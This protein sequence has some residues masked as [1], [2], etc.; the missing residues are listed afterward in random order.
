MPFAWVVAVRFLRE[1]RFQTLLIVGGVALGVAVIVF[2]TTIINGL[3][4][5]VIE[6]TLGSQ[7]HIVVRPPDEVVPPLRE[8]ARLQMLHRIQPRAQRLRSIDQWQALL[9]IIADQPGV[10][11]VAP[12]ASGPG[13][14]IRGEANRAIALLG[15]EPERFSRVVDL[16]GKLRTGQLRL[17][18]EDALIGL[19]L[20][21]ELGL[22]LGDRLRLET[23]GGRGSS[24]RV[25][26]LFDLGMRDLNLRYV[27]IGLRPAQSL[28]DLPGGISSIEV[29]VVDVFEAEAIGDRIEAQTGLIADSWMETNRELLSA[30][31]SQSIATGMIRFFVAISVAFGI[32]SV[33]AISVV[34]R[35]REIGILRAT[36]TSRRAIMAVF[37]L[38]GALLGL[39]GSLVGSAMATLLIQL[40]TR[41]A[42]GF[43]FA[44]QI[45]PAVLVGAA[46]LATLTGLVA[47]A[48]PALRAARLNPVDAIR[49]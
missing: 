32:A 2:I 33:L 38:Q 16:A 10:V 31:R 19:D 43:P 15:I 21:Y 18:A 49:G 14:A 30:L 44:I 27:Y 7:A 35:S 8:A 20:A 48:A 29:R 40:F 12:V 22:R 25:A 17:D 34:Q 24:F 28:L 39:L 42:T 46:L 47:A 3:Q 45:S 26:G 5:R 23:V 41:V 9:P 13:L 37:L 36:G 1:G 4:A 6:D 11:A